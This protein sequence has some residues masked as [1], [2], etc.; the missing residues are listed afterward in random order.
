MPLY[1]YLQTNQIFTR[2]RLLLSQYLQLSHN[3]LIFIQ[4]N[5]INQLA[6]QYKLEYMLAEWL[7][8]DKHTDHE[9]KHTIK[10]ILYKHNTGL[11]SYEPVKQKIC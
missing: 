8:Y 1:K 9:I 4:L 3:S 7:L 5:K 2:L 6:K 10:S 11:K